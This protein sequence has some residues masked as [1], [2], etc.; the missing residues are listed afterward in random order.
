MTRV[1]YF[2]QKS[3]DELVANIQEHVAWYC[4]PRGAGPVLPTMVLQHRA[5]T[6]ESLRRHPLQPKIDADPRNCRIVFDAMAGLTR[7]QASDERLWTYLCH[8]DCKDYV[9][10][11]WPPS[12]KRNSDPV[13]RV[14]QHFFARGARSLLRSNGV[15]RLWWAG[16]VA[17]DVAEL[18]ADEQRFLQMLHYRQDVRT[19]LLERPSTTRNPRV[20]KAI[21]DVM[22]DHWTDDGKPLFQRSRFRDW[23]KRLDLTGGTR[24]L[25]AL[26]DRDLQAVT[27]GQAERSLMAS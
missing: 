6:V 20:L 18:G 5:L 22:A 9:A 1:Q 19:S 24:L 8:T 26:S 13:N 27:E 10:A 7:H 2:R 15:S 21:Y 17:R 4:D 12:T 25:D 11:R 14:R 23:M 3:V 16:R